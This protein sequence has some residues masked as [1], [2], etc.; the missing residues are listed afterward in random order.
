MKSVWESKPTSLDEFEG[1]ETVKKSLS[2][3]LE[4]AKKRGTPPD[5]VL[6]V[7]PPGLGKTNLVEVIINELQ[8]TDRFVKVA[9]GAVAS[10]ND[11]YHIIDYIRARPDLIVFID[12][13]HALPRKYAEILYSVMQDGEIDGE[14]IRHGFTVIGATT[15]RGKIAKPLMDRFKHVYT[16]KY[17]KDESIKKILV[18]IV[19]G[20][21]KDVT[22]RIAMR[23]S[24]VPRVAKNLLNECMNT[25]T[26]NNRNKPTVKDVRDTFDRLAIDEYGLGETDRDILKYLFKNG[27]ASEKTLCS[28]F[29]L[30]KDDLNF[31]HEVPMLKLGFLDKTSR[32]RM[33]TEHGATYAKKLIAADK[34]M[35]TSGTTTDS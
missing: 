6:L 9:G 24:G 23:A 17:Y 8:A 4:A 2:V 16:L 28:V 5:H 33:L 22:N 31:I 26:V 19:P 35:K 15:N 25:A 21:A 1:Q 29:E 32:G 14:K 20:I 3:T 30:A 18:Q 10:K 13:I 7:G 27:R 34:K 11:V 12:E